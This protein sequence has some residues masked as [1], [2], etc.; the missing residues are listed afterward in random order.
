MVS[1]VIT[2]FDN[3][4][5]KNFAWRNSYN[6]LVKGVV[7]DWSGTTCDKYVIAPAKAF[8]EIFDKYGITITMN[9]A[10][11]P[12]GLRK[13][14]H[15]KALLE[16]PNIQNKWK[17][18]YGKKSTQEDVDKIFKEF[19]PL[20]LSCLRNYAELIPGTVDTAK[21]LRS[22]NI[23]IGTSTGFTKDMVKII[24]E[25]TV[26]Q[27]YVPD[28]VVAGDEV[29]N[30]SRPKPFMVYKNCDIL[31]IHPIQSVVKVDDT[32]SGIG[33]GLEAGCWTVGVAMYSNYMDIN[34][35]EEEKMLKQ[36]GEY[37]D[38][39]NN[40]REILI[41]RGAHY[42]VDSIRDLPQVIEHINI[43]LKNGEYPI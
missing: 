38:R 40:S 1:K 23:K 42:V 43:R 9:E 21:W 22:N 6:G 11:I 19:V 3:T 34:S 5:K 26:K 33:E 24:L 27:G 36:T 20:Q 28:A 18:K 8:V 10:R 7:L 30:G 12:M 32:T 39:L 2:I 37:N 13:D 31:D 41:K 14:L 17:N 25:E 15:I 29:I 35:Y 4:V 16:L